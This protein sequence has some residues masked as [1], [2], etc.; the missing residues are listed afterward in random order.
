MLYFPSNHLLNLPTRAAFLRERC[1]SAGTV[2][3]L[4]GSLFCKCDLIHSMGIILLVGCCTVRPV[5][6]TFTEAPLTSLS[7]LHLISSIILLIRHRCLSALSSCINTTSLTLIYG[8]LLFN[9]LNFWYSRKSVAYLAHQRC[10]KWLIIL[11]YFSL[12]S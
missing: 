6:G 1:G 4:S 5:L 9:H 8:E 10:Q 12:I 3:N 7:D 2:L 11:V